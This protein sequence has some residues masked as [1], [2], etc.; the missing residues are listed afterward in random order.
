MSTLYVDNLEP[1]LGN[2]VHSTGA[3]LQTVYAT[4]DTYNLVSTIDTWTDVG[5]EVSITPKFANSL[6]RIDFTGGFR[7][8][9]YTVQSTL[10]I[11]RG[12]YRL[13]CTRGSGVLVGNESSY[14]ELMQFRP[15]SNTAAR[16]SEM[17]YPA[18]MIGM[19][20][21]GTTDQQTYKVQLYMRNG[22]SMYLTH[23]KS[24]RLVATEIAQ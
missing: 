13:L 3:V 2:A 21:P 4:H 23:Q 12:S 18:A 8:N 10:S 11:T 15:D 22:S 19:D 5:L 7:I 16:G 14:V 24:S 17:N 1:N 9:G 20:L 6:I